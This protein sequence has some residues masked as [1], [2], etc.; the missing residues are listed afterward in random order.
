MTP[1]IHELL[2]LYALDLLDPEQVNYVERAI[3]DDAALAAELLA[4]REA[5]A[6]LVA[7]APPIVPSPELKLRLLASAGGGRFE[8]FAA[9]FGEIYDVTIVRARE[10]LGLIERPASWGAVGDIAPGSFL[11]HFDP[12]PS[13]AAADCGFVRLAPGATFPLHTHN[14]EELSLV[15]C[16]KLR[17]GTTVLSIG[18]EL[19]LP[20]GSSHEITAVGDVDCIF[21][22]RAR[23]GVV[24]DGIRL[25][26]R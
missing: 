4:Y 1:D 22:A 21:A 25:G 9:R 7:A 20:A 6:E 8:R 18:D 26:A 12:G 23:N 3:A 10:I 24:I 13:H 16:G 14:G 11:V 5:S 17:S 15:L 19:V 2:A